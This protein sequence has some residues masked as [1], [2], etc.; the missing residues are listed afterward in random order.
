MLVSAS[1]SEIMAVQTAKRAT[2]DEIESEAKRQQTHHKDWFEETLHAKNL[3][4][5]RP[6]GAEIA[7]VGGHFGIPERG[8]NCKL[9]FNNFLV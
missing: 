7:I 3:A 6:E 5:G 1:I 9:L 8:V 4:K 2:N